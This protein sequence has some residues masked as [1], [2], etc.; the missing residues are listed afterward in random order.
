M[1]SRVP[2]QRR[3]RRRAVIA[4][5]REHGWSCSPEADA[6][7]AADEAVRGREREALLACASG[8]EL[9]QQGYEHDVTIAAEVNT[10]TVIPVLGV[11]TATVRWC[12]RSG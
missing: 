5:L 12:A 3:H 1:P 8:R 10:S 6:A 4:H 9:D 2:A 11:G 7:R